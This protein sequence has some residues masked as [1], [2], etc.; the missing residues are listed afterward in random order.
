M[1]EVADDR[2][3][4]YVDVNALPHEHPKYGKGG[5]SGR[6]LF[7]Y[8]NTLVKR[9]RERT[10]KKIIGCGGISNGIDVSLMQHSGADSFQALTGFVYGGPRFAH[11]VNKEYLELN[12][13]D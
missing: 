10:G 13:N 9:T 6:I 2:M 11:K 5:L 8:A 3:N 1:I 12:K 7:P 4:G